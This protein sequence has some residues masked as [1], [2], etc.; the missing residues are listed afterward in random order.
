MTDCRAE[1]EEEDHKKNLQMYVFLAR[2]IAYPFNGQQTGDMARRQMKVNKQE[3]TRIRD[4]FTSFLKGETNIAADEAFTKAIQSYFEV[5]LKSERVQKVVHAGGFSQ[6]D[7]R[8]VFRLNIEKR[9]RSLPDIEG[10]SK[11]T[12]LNSWLAKFDAIIKGD[13]TDQN[14]N[15]R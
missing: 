1:K 9:I 12:V 4:R 10:L 15:A 14:R 7:F 3:L 13:E 6:H 2:C 8:E 5:F 11:D